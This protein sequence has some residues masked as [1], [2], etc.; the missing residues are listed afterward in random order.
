MTTKAMAERQ[1][2]WINGIPARTVGGRSIPLPPELRSS[3]KPQQSTRPHTSSDVQALIT[4]ILEACDEARE[5]SERQ[6]R[7]AGL[8]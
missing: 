4:G 6:L 1:A 5:G 8:W 7:E 3:R 2:D